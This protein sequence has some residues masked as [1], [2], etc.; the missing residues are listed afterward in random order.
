MSIIR[1]IR[2]SIHQKVLRLINERLSAIE[3]L[4][5]NNIIE[6][7]N[8]IIECENLLKKLKQLHIRLD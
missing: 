7:Q 5:G 3:K 6:L 4:D 1:S 2:G 8:E